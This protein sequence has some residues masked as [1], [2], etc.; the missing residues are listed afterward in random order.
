MTYSAIYCSLIE[1]RRSN[2]LPDG[3][4]GEVHHIIPKSEGGDN[5]QDNLIRLSA[6]EHYVAHLLL[7]KIYE[8]YKMYSALV[9]MRCGNKFV[10]RNFKFNSRLYEAIRKEYGR[11]IS[12]K[13]HWNYGKPPWNKGI[14]LSDEQKEKLRKALTGRHLKESTKEKLR[15]KTHTD[16]WKEKM[17][18]K[19][20]GKNNPF[21]GKSHTPETMKRIKAKLTGRSRSKDACEKAS[22]SI[23]KLKW[24]NNGKENVRKRECPDGF[25]AGR[26]K[27]KSSE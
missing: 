9:Y 24:W 23:H 16:E 21:Y 2:P 10:N 22:I 4:Y 19:M 27:K 3:E 26:L 6:M 15:G 14:P 1:R 7:A 8:D 5:S 17:S 18:E 13:N 25:V 12:G 11:K 20:S